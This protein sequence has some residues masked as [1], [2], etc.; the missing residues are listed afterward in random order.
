MLPEAAPPEPVFFVD[1]SLGGK[2]VVAALRTAGAQV[3]IHDDV[4]AQNTPDVDWLAEAG[5]RGWVVLTKD[6][7]IR[8]HP[9]EKAMFQAA[10][11]RVFTLARQNLPGREMGELFASMLPGM[12]KR[13][14]NVSPPFIFS[15]SR[16]GAFTR[17]D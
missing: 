4:F 15:I 2:F 1:R 14:A 9:H 16:G 8:R 12:R 5:R 7:A 13:V 3:V 10:C 17:L 11:V 6:A